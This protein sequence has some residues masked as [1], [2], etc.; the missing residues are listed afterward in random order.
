MPEEEPA[1]CRLAGG[2]PPDFLRRLFE[3]LAATGHVDPISKVAYVPERVDATAWVI[4]SLLPCTGTM[5]AE[6][7]HQLGLPA[8][9]TFAEGAHQWMA[10]RGLRVEDLTILPP[11]ASLG[12]PDP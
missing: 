7:C 3:Q 1:L 12:D 11:R 9:A 10:A 5:P 4:R 8:G 2:R 6:L